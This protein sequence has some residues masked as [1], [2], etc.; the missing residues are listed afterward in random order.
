MK[1]KGKPMYLFFD[2]ETTGLPTNWKAP[3]GEAWPH[4]VSISWLLMSDIDTIHERGNFIVKPDGYE[5]PGQ[6]SNVHGI[7]TERALAEGESLWEVLQQFW[8]S[9]VKA[10]LLIAHNMSFDI[11]V[12]KSAIIRTGIPPLLGSFALDDMPKYCT[13]DESVEV[14]KIPGPYGYK[15]PKLI[16]LYKHFFG[17]EFDDQ[18]S[19]DADTL[20]CAKC[21]FELQNLSNAQSNY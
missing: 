17:E 2:T 16:E 5:I 1:P 18:H 3:A 19:S 10:D 6:S 13:K 15:W 12:L 4:I 7:T 8:S 11:M 9:Y 14:C 20:A 21:F